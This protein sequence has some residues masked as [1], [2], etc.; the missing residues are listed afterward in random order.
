MP[1]SLSHSGALVHLVQLVDYTAVS[2]LLSP[3]DP[4]VILVLLGQ[5][6]QI[7]QGLRR[8]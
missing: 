1:P 7:P 4:L 8:S 6:L 3:L 5:I 2:H